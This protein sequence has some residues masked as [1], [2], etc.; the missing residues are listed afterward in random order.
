[1]SANPRSGRTIDEIAVGRRHWRE[2]Y[3][4][5]AAAAMEA[6]SNLVRVRE[7]AV[8][9]MEE[10]LAELDLNHL[11]YDVLTVVAAAGSRG[12]RLG[13]IGQRAQKFFGHQT[14]ITNVVLRLAERGFVETER[15]PDD[16][17]A[18]LVRLTRT[19]EQR[20]RAANDALTAVRFGI[21]VLSTEELTQL[22]RLLHKVRVAHGDVD[23]RE[24]EE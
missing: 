22:A 19:G 10:C 11:E 2:R 6:V 23:D 24:Q 14:S 8:H 17:R 4:R 13:R 1:M 5:N 18:T 21:G 15:D 16:Q 3:G 20:L 9:R 12:V 7:L